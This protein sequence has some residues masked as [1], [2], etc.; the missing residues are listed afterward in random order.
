MSNELFQ[1][2]VPSTSIL[3]GG[4]SFKELLGRK[5]R[6]T[7]EYE[8]E[9]PNFMISEQLV[10]GGVESYR[11]TY[12]VACNLDM[13]DAYDRVLDLGKSHWLDEMRGNLKRAK[14][15]SEGLKHLRI[16]FDD[17]PCYEFICRSF[18]VY[19]EERPIPANYYSTD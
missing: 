19:R 15:N 13:I 1:L 6:L 16:F 3:R 5:C 4:A 8:S 11:C 12:Y 10:F 17:G 2:P 7:Y 9:K 18:D 14:W